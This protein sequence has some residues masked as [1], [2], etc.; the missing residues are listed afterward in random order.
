MSIAPSLAANLLTNLN[1]SMLRDARRHA[2]QSAILR[3]KARNHVDEWAEST[4]L[5]L[6]EEMQSRL[7]RELRNLVYASILQDYDSPRFRPLEDLLE[8]YPHLRN[9]KYMGQETLH[10]LAG[11]WYQGS[12]FTFWSSND[13]A[14]DLFR[15]GRETWRLLDFEPAQHIRHV[16][17]HTLSQERGDSGLPKNFELLARLQKLATLT[18]VM[19]YDEDGQLEYGLPEDFACVLRSLMDAGTRV[20]VELAGN[21]TYSAS[22]SIEHLDDESW[23]KFMRR[24]WR[25]EA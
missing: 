13:D 16:T 5:S 24:V 20:V 8:S 10:E 3:N 11:E 7:P 4:C 21:Y 9:P 14:D 2:M 23:P 15:P 12:G 18:L 6:C 1:N 25:F 17:L 22:V 19:G